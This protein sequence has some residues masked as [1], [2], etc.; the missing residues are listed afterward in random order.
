MKERVARE[1]LVE[2]AQAA[3]GDENRLKAKRAVV[4]H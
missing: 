2:N 4:L 1:S 3:A